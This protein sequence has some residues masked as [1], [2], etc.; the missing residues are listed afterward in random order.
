MH[1]SSFSFDKRKE[2]EDEELRL[3]TAANCF[4]QEVGRAS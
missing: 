4:V 1:S 2:I 3:A